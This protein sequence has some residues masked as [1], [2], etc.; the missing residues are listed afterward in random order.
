MDWLDPLPA[1]EAHRIKRHTDISQDPRYNLQVPSIA[2][3]DAECTSA[4]NRLPT[5]VLP[6]EETQALFEE[7]QGIAPD[8]IYERGF[9]DTIDPDKTNFDK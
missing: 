9:P 2:G 8:L 1:T 6:A 7:G 5:Y 3:Y 4:P